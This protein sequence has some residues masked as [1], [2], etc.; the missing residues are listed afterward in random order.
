MNSEIADM[1]NVG[2]RG[3]DSTQA[4]CF[5]QRYIQKGV[6]WAHIDIAGCEADE[7]G[8]ATGFGVLLLNR[9]MNLT[10]KK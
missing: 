9:L 8:L 3:A 7:K 1:K 5:L 6:R 2:K 10:G 4:A